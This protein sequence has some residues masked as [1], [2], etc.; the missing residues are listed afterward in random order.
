MKLRRCVNEA[1]PELVGVASKFFRHTRWCYE[2]A[3][4]DSRWCD[5][6]VADDSWSCDAVAAGGSGDV[7]SPTRAAGGASLLLWSSVGLQWSSPEAVSA[8]IEASL[9]CRCCA[10]APSGCNG[11]HPRTTASHAATTGPT[12]V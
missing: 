3:P 2:A 6:A 5:A 11:A 10:G 1:S 8:G 7:R 12:M 4:G 9:E